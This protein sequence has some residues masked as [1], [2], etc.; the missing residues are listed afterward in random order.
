MEKFTCDSPTESPSA[1]E[2]S[3]LRVPSAVWKVKLSV[4]HLP[5]KELLRVAEQRLS[6]SERRAVLSGISFP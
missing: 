3:R 6:C 2:T 1:A 4:S 5:Q